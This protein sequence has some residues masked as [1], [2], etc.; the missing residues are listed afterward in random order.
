MIQEREVLKGFDSTLY[1]ALLAICLAIALIAIFAVVRSDR[2]TV[3]SS[4]VSGDAPPKKYKGH[5]RTEVMNPRSTG[6][7]KNWL[8]SGDPAVAVATSADV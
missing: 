4:H 1:R 7:V 8:R 2:P 6:R 3:G 5:F